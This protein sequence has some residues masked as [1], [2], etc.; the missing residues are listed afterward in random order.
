M[1][2]HAILLLAHDGQH[3]L[4]DIEGARQVAGDQ[5]VDAFRLQPLPGA[6]GDVDAGV[7]DDDVEPAVVGLD[8]GDDLGDG[9]RSW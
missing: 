6:V 5:G 2:Q 7:V 1:D 8:A 9:R 3:G 4:D